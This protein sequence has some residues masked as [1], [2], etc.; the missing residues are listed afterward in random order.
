VLVNE[1][2]YISG[3]LG[4]NPET[5]DFVSEDTAEQTKQALMNMGNVLEAAGSSF[6]KGMYMYL[7]NLTLLDCKSKFWCRI[8]RFTSIAG[9]H[10]LA[11][12]VDLQEDK[13]FVYAFSRHTN[14]WNSKFNL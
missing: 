14:F 5:M 7:L 8:F 13:L 11:Y 3:Q 1:T 12:C 9:L 2:L 10:K 4:L 6:Q